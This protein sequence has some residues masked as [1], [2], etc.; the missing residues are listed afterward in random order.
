LE[1]K[2]MNLDIS[3]ASSASVNVVQDLYLDG[4][5]VYTLKI[6]GNPL[7]HRNSGESYSLPEKR[8]DDKVIDHS[9]KRVPYYWNNFVWMGVDL[10]VNGFVDKGGR[11][12][13]T[14]PYDFMELN[15]GKSAN[16]R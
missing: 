10:G 16:V 8:E 6:E 15:Y 2:K 5:G 11:F 13:P 1:V 14:S 9:N 7:I 3:G 4:S 12:Q